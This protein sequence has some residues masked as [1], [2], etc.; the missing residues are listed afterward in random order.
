MI[1]FQAVGISYEPT[2]EC[3]PTLDYVCPSISPLLSIRPPLII[4]ITSLS[5]AGSFLCDINPFRLA[6]TLPQ[7][8]SV[9]TVQSLSP[10]EY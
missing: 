10:P 4:I 1:S 8:G 5:V 9:N 6:T 7:T 3:G 2:M